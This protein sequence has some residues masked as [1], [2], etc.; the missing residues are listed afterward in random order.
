M[1]N[2]LDLLD[3]FSTATSAMGA[4]PVIARLASAKW[5]SELLSALITQ[6]N[7]PDDIALVCDKLTVAAT[8]ITTA[9]ELDP[10]DHACYNIVIQVMAPVASKELATKGEL[11]LAWKNNFVSAIRSF[12]PLVKIM[13]TPKN[14]GNSLGMTLSHHYSQLFVMAN[15]FSFLREPVE[16]VNLAHKQINDVAQFNT[17]SLTKSEDGNIIFQNQLNSL[18]N[19]YI[20]VYKKEAEQWLSMLDKEPTIKTLCLNGIPM[21][22]VN[23]HFTEQAQQLSSM[24]GI[25]SENSK[26][27]E[28]TR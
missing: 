16:I 17:S 11:S 15:E 1:G 23:Q 20:S 22:S 19:I 14:A 3:Q 21:D 9:L 5:Q 2:D 24:I 18:R 12:P 7:T 28:I 4:M 8:E 13:N 6:G 10:K 25:E 27:E 26:S